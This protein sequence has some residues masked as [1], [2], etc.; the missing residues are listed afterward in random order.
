MAK[1]NVRNRNKNL[2]DKKPNWEY[3]FESAKVDGKR[4]AISKAG[5]RTKKEALEAGAKALSE[6]NSAGEVFSPSEISVSDYFDFWVEKECKINFAYNTQTNYISLIRT[7]I[8]PAFGHLKLRA[9][10]PIIL[11]Q[12][13]N[14]LVVKGYSFSTI[15]GVYCLLRA[16][17]EYAVYPAKFIASNPAK[18]TTMP[19]VPTEPTERAVIPVE[20]FNEIID[21]FPFGDRYHIPLLLGWSCGLRINEAPAVT[22]DD[23]DF[24]NKTLTINKQLL[25]R[26]LQGVEDTDHYLPWSFIPPKY[27][28]K[29]TIRIGDS[30]LNVLKEEKLRQEALETLYGDEYKIYQLKEELVKGVGKVRRI[31]GGEKSSFK[32]DERERNRLRFICVD[33]NGALTTDGLIAYSSKKIKDFIDKRYTY[34]CLRHTHATMLIENGANPKSVQ[35]RLGHTNIATTMQIYVHVTESM[36]QE[37]VDLFEKITNEAI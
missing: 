2:P 24:E 29:R 22:W 34:H 11:Q 25:R 6:Y 36:K 9:V 10:S 12:Y 37:A 18:H 21:M 26:K 5:F 15:E 30:L 27:G 33:K 20:E 19:T 32:D 35:Q 1:I 8:K 14:E 13:L 31:I 17:L 28:S 16:A 4:K 3:R 7:K 23:V